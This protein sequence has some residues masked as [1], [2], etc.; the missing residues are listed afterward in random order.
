MQSAYSGLLLN[1][2]IMID[3][4]A[5]KQVILEQSRDLADAAG[6]ILNED[7][8]LLEEVTG[9]VEWP[10]PVMGTIDDHF[11]DVPP[12][13][14]ITSMKAHQKYFTLSTKDGKLAPRFITI[15]NMVCADGGAAIIAGNERVL[16]ARLHDA[17][18]FWDNDRKT[19]LADRVRGLEKI[20]FH[21]RLGTVHDRVQRL[22]G[23]SRVLSEDIPNCEG[24]LADRAA[25]LCKSDLTTG[26]VSEFPELQG[27][28]GRYYARHDGEAEP[29][30]DAIAQHYRP[31]GPDDTC[32]RDP[33][34]VALALAEKLDMLAGFFA[35][36]EKPTGSKDPFAL[37]RAALGVIRLILENKLRLPLRRIFAEA[38]NQ[39]PA[40][41]ARQAAVEDLFGFFA[42]RLTVYLKAKGARHDL[43]AA[44]FALGDEDDLVRLLARVDALDGFLR[45]DDGSVLM[46][47][48]KRAANILKIEQKKDKTVYDG[49]VNADLLSEQAERV[50]FENLVDVRHK[51]LDAVGQEDF[52]AAMAQFARLRAPVDAF[53]DTVTVN[54]DAPELRANRLR[55]LGQIR[56]SM[57]VVA[58]FSKV[59]GV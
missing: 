49:A 26:M 4:E 25:A 50:L 9:L 27:V 13:V 40:E 33:V 20:V 1:A 21:A 54:V 37:R 52:S 15:S 5:R 34:A 2:K 35:I 53:F 57:D 42:D 10:V 28:I 7:A 3:R 36:D 29:V 22:R 12:E 38:I 51:A 19:R 8:G 47:G 43:I 16:R 18:F 30:A 6:L 45:S 14:L 39:Y 17:K 48:Y 56:Q 31:A 55:L 44:V 24:A 23:L 58:D 59:E 11:M 41:I 46:A 32:P